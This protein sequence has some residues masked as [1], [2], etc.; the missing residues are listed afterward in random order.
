[1][2]SDTNSLNGAGTQHSPAPSLPVFAICDVCGGAD[3]EQHM[4]DGMCRQCIGILR[5][6][7]GRYR[8][9]DQSKTGLSLVA[10]G[11]I[12]FWTAIIAWRMFR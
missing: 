5:Q 8:E 9:K 6:A 7:L 3:E 1:M 4:W 10:L 2:T 11:C 12:V